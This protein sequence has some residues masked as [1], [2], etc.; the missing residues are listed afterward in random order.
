MNFNSHK[1][2]FI[3]SS[4]WIS[5]VNLFAKSKVDILKRYFDVKLD[6]SKSMYMNALK[7]LH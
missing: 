6:L 1:Q 5:V 7:L 3:A 2:I 4:D